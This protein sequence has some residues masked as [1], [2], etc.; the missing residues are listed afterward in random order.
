VL[1]ATHTPEWLTPGHVAPAG[2]QA[3][4]SFAPERMHEP[5]PHGA[6]ASMPAPRWRCKVEARGG[7]LHVI[8]IE[9]RASH[10][11]VRGDFTG[12]EP[13]RLE[14]AG[15]G[16]WELR[17]HLTPGVHQV[18]VAVDDGAWQPPPGLPRTAGPYGG[19]VGV[20]VAS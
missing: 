17:I 9:G 19:E 7:D 4:I 1:L 6:S 18:E 16:R 2:V 15:L 3:A 13:V 12:W 11:T 20:I 5:M 10:V 8:G 14:E